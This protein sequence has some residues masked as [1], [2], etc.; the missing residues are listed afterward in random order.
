MAHNPR[1]SALVKELADADRSQL[2]VAVVLGLV[3]DGGQ[4]GGLLRRPGDQQRPDALQGNTDRGATRPSRGGTPR[5]DAD[6][7]EQER[8]GAVGALGLS[9]LPAAGRAPRASGSAITSVSRVAR[10]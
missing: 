8:V 1:G 2:V 10:G 9:P 5:G 3:V 7:G 6:V 4:R